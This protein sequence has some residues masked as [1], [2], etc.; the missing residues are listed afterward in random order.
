MTGAGLVIPGFTHYIASKMAVV[1]Q[2][3]AIKRA[4]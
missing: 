1:P 3:Q 2:M 4:G